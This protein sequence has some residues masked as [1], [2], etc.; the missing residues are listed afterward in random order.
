MEEVGQ[1]ASSILI[2]WSDNIIKDQTRKTPDPNKP[3]QI[4]MNIFEIEK[5]K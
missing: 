1:K 2:L 4:E 5:Q 3:N